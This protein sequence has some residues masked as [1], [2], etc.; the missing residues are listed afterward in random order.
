VAFQQIAW[1][2]LIIPKFIAAFME[3]GNCELHDNIEKNHA[4]SI[5]HED[6][7]PTKLVM[8]DRLPQKA[9][10]EYNLTE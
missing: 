6:F 1:Q 4:V 10:F 3:Q 5:L 9:F 7:P 2:G 8:Y